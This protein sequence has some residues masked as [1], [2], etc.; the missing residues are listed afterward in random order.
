MPEVRPD[1]YLRF[2][3]YDAMRGVELPTLRRALTEDKRRL[4]ADAV[5]AAIKRARWE[6]PPI[7]VAPIQRT[8]GGRS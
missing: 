4:L 3:I 6:I 8:G 1:D 5:F 2:A 7:I